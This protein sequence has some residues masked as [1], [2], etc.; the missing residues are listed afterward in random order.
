MRLYG[1]GSELGRLDFIEFFLAHRALHFVRQR[2]R[3]GPRISLRIGEASVKIVEGDGR[4]LRVIRRHQ[5]DFHVGDGDRLIAVVG[6]NKIDG[7][8][9]VLREI[10]GKNLGFLG[11]VIGVGGDGDFFLAMEIVRRVIDRRLCHRLDEV[12]RRQQ[13]R[14]EQRETRQNQQT[15]SAPK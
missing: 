1:P 13:N 2:Q 6:Y 8:I 10:D 9:A 5:S 12:L 11:R 4:Q 7:Q 3:T 14:H 15:A